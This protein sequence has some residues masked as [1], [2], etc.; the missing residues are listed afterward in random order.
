MPYRRP[1]SPGRAG[2]AGVLL[3]ALLSVAG[4][5]QLPEDD[6]ARG[7]RD[8]AAGQG[9][10]AVDWRRSAEADRAA[11]ERRKQLLA[12]GLGPDEAA[13]VALLSDPDLQARF[14]ELGIA[15]GAYL[16]AASAPNPFISWQRRAVEG[17]GSIVE[18]GLTANLIDLL[19]LPARRRAAAGELEGARLAAADAVLHTAIGARER[20]LR[21]LAAQRIVA[22]RRDHADLGRLAF[23]LAGRFRDAGN[24]TAIEFEEQ[25]T[26]HLEARRALEAAELAALEER[27]G[28]LRALGVVGI[29]DGLQVKGAL[30][31][32]PA[33]DP[34]TAALE[35]SALGRRLDLRAAR[36]E[37][38]ARLQRLSLARSTRLLSGLEVGYGREKASGEPR[39][40]G[41][42]LGLELPLFTQQQAA[43]AEGDAAARLAM[44]RAEGL[45][46]DA[47][48][49]VRS[50]EA[51]MREA[52]RRAA[53]W[54]DEVLPARQA[55]VDGQKREFF[56]MLRGPFDPM[57]A[58]QASLEAEIEAVEALR[59]YWLARAALAL[60]T[61]D[62]GLADGVQR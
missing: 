53:T 17:G 4:C 21:L 29:D 47:R 59:D 35:A 48:V 24:I 2:R 45:A 44:R 36:A 56:Y 13:Q 31:A 43:L 60:A 26:H 32:L 23:E 37:A 57:R 62:L 33:A 12:D 22:L 7:V 50:A 30:P 18:W 5:A 9:A 10:P 8:L 51:A 34:D 11:A 20:H 1:A 41:P 19:T 61:G 46:L 38:E 40:Q 58:K 14:E 39:A 3:A 6:L 27:L 16:A 25:R 49:Q 42:S 52:R 55:I 54:Q 28:L 15:R